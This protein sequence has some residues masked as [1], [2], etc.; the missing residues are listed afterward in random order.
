MGDF[1]WYSALSDPSIVTVKS[2]SGAGIWSQATPLKFVYASLPYLSVQQ[3]GDP[4]E[5]ASFSYAKIARFLTEFSKQ[6]IIRFQVYK[7]L[8]ITTRESRKSWRY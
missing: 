6:L 2:F 3:V 8:K 1:I 4:A 7:N 5:L